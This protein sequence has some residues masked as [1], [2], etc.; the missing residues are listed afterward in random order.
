[1]CWCRRFSLFSSF[2]GSL[3]AGQAQILPFCIYEKEILKIS[4]NY[5]QLIFLFI[6][7]WC[8]LCSRPLFDVDSCFLCRCF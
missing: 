7:F 2:L 1:M 3:H 6:R 8:V 4:C 5:A